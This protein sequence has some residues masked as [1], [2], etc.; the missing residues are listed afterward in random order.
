MTNNLYYTP[1]Y[2][3]ARRQR[4]FWE[5]FS[6]WVR[7]IKVVV[8]DFPI[9]TESYYVELKPGDEGYEDAPFMSYAISTDPARYEFKNGTYR[10]VA[11]KKT[12]QQKWKAKKGKAY[13]ARKQKE[14]RARKKA[15]PR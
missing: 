4:T 2:K 1:R 13:F 10:P 9:D 5:R 3:M 12:P 14:R 11:P 15:M 8:S 7:S 6:I